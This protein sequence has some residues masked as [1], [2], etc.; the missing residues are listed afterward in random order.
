MLIPPHQHVSA[1]V[2]PL[3]AHMTAS[4]EPAAVSSSYTHSDF[5]TTTA[6]TLY[7]QKKGSVISCDDSASYTEFVYIHNTYV[8]AHL[9]D[10]TNDVTLNLILAWLPC[11]MIFNGERNFH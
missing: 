8:H 5:P 10:V 7:K 3:P 11:S 6:P 2:S 9:C 1:V 4:L